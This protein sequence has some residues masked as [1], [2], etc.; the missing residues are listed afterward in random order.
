MCA[1]RFVRWC[2]LYI[3]TYYRVLLKSVIHSAYSVISAAPPSVTDLKQAALAHR[4]VPSDQPTP[5]G[6]LFLTLPAEEAETGYA[7]TRAHYATMDAHTEEASGGCHAHSGSDLPSPEPCNGHLNVAPVP[8]LRCQYVAH[9]MGAERVRER[10]PRTRLVE[11]Q[12][13][14]VPFTWYYA[15]GGAMV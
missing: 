11:T 10:H 14:Y 2:S 1:Q 3:R 13:D 8:E 12:A 15:G 7:G 5:V 4:D 6:Q 9:C